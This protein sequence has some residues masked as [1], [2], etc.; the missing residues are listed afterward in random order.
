MARTL[1]ESKVVECD[2]ETLDNLIRD[3]VADEEGE[4]WETSDISFDIEDDEL[5][6]LIRARVTL[7]KLKGD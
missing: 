1:S 4:D 5:P 2:L 3:W 6:E 7:R